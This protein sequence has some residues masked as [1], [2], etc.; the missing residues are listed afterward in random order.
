M[1]GGLQPNLLDLHETRSAMTKDVPRHVLT[2]IIR[3]LGVFSVCS[4]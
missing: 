4:V 1:Q 3:G 2:I